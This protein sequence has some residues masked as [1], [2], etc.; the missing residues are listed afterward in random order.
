MNTVEIDPKMFWG[1]VIGAGTACGGILTWVF[2]YMQNRLTTLE[3]RNETQA[4]K[5]MAIQVDQTEIQRSTVA[6]VEK[7]NDD[8]E[9]LIMNV[10]HIGHKLEAIH[11]D[12]KE[13]RR[14][15]DGE[16]G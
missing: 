7:A 11:E 8:R 1:V 5:L 2:R 9:K 6:A 3:G 10:A 15:R 4:D 12:V 16:Q 14:G 13:V